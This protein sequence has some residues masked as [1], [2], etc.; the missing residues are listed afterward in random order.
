MTATAKT[1][2]QRKAPHC[3]SKQVPSHLGTISKLPEHGDEPE[4]AG[5]ALA[6]VDLA[7]SEEEDVEK[8]A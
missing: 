3:S 7:G 6:T 5:E 1:E 4:A 8:S 2:K